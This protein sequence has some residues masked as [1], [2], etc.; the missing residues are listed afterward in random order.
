MNRLKLFI[1]LIVF[2]VL[3]V[4]LG[5][6]LQN[7]PSELPSALIGKPLPEFS[8]PN[9]L[10]D[11]QEV[12]NKDLHG[13]PYLLNVWATWCP[14]CRSEH[15]FLLELKK[16]GVII[17]GVDYKDDNEAAK[18]WLNVLGD[19]YAFNVVDA[20]GK[21]GLDLGVY[22]APETYVVDSQGIVRYRHVGVVD[23]QVWQQIL[24]PLMM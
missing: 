15:P 8:L 16:R 7:D 23:E 10:D 4:F 12:S 13:K 2:A 24:A 19:P 17:V 14:S 5:I 3:A 1:P 21:F 6:G 20:D 9:L 22:G 18:K 11:N